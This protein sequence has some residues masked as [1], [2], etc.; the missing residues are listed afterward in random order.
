VA[1]FRQDTDTS[2][3]ISKFRVAPLKQL[4]LPRLELMGATVAA[5]IFTL[6]KSS[7]HHQIDSVHMWCDSQIVLHWLNSDKK[8]KQFVSNRVTTITQ[9]CPP[10]WWHNCPS[11]ENPADL[12]TRSI[13]LFR[14]GLKDLRV[15]H[16]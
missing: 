15:D 14:T 10:H 3:V 5:Q 2:F 16:M 13:S 11:A 8:L 6:V 4:M 7:L 12:L 9:I 1:Y